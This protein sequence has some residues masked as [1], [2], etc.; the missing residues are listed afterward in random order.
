[1]AYF[2][3]NRGFGKPI[4]DP[5]DLPEKWSAKEK[6]A[7]MADAARRH[8]KARYLLL[9]LIPFVLTVMFDMTWLFILDPLVQMLG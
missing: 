3:I 2:V 6:S 9:W 7:Y 5:A 1:V 4:T 8:Q